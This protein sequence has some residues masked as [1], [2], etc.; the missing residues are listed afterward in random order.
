[1]TGTPAETSSPRIGVI[2]GGQLARMLVEAAATRQ[3]EV[4]VQSSSRQDPAGQ[5]VEEM[6][7]ADPV[8]AGASR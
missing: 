4:V 7:L 8:D 2:G 6:V 3:I 1:M 5:L